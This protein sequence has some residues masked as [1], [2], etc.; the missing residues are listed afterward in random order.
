MEKNENTVINS[1]KAI[2]II[3]FF[4]TITGFIVII[5]T[6]LFMRLRNLP[7]FGEC[8]WTGAMVLWI[9]AQFLPSQSEKPNTGEFYDQGYEYSVT[10]PKINLVAQL[11]LDTIIKPY[12]DDEDMQ[13]G[14]YQ[15]YVI[16]QN[17]D[18]YLSTSLDRII[19]PTLCKG[20]G[21]GIQLY[22]N[23]Y[24]GN[25]FRVLQRKHQTSDH[26]QYC[27]IGFTILLCISG[28]I[29]YLA[30]QLRAFAPTP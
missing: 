25:T 21:K 12:I 4:C 17:N 22:A 29:H 23:D 15:V 7:T 8:F 9:A 5:S 1:L 6:R 16:R 28:I 18:Y 14:N 13:H 24:P 30:A 10:G 20:N 11:P 26:T 3:F 2:G 27:T 19:E